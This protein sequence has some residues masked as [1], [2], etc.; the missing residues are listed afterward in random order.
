MNDLK[1]L[2][3]KASALRVKLQNYFHDQYF[4][5]QINYIVGNDVS[6]AAIA[7]AESES[8]GNFL[9]ALASVKNRDAEISNLSEPALTKFQDGVNQF[10]SWTSGCRARLAE[11]KQL[12]T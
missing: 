1:A 12:V 7:Q 8:L 3:E 4:D 2:R 10:Y 5:Q 6:K 11:I 9:R